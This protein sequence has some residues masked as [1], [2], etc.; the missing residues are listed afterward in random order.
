MVI[1]KSSPYS[2][3]V[4][5]FV[6]HFPVGRGVKPPAPPPPGN[7]STYICCST[8]QATERNT[9]SLNDFALFQATCWLS[10]CQ[11][12]VR[13]IPRTF[14]AEFRMISEGN[15]APRPCIGKNGGSDIMT[16]RF[17]TS[18]IFTWS[19]SRRVSFGSSTNQD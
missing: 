1:L 5:H 15:Q 3:L 9:F 4:L 10:A 6:Q 7:G 18:E 16:S 8:V 13:P 2:S 17:S 11:S 14:S 12:C 19:R